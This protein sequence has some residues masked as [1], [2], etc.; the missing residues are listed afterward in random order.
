MGLAKKPRPI[1]KVRLIMSQKEIVKDDTA[2][3][4]EVSGMRKMVVRGGKV[5]AKV[6]C[7]AG[8]EY[9]RKAKTCVRITAAES[10]KRAKSSKKA[11][12]TRKAHAGINR[13]HSAKSRRKSLKI[14]TSRNVA[15]KA[16]KR[17]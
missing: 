14:R 2:A 8:Y 7:P 11:S 17:V 6:E 12:R 3:I 16:V 1:Q 13:V 15:A 9:D 4:E 5:V 10:V